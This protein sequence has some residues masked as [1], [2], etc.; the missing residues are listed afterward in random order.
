MGAISGGVGGHGR[1]KMAPVLSRHLD[2]SDGTQ[3]DASVLEGVVILALK[4]R[5]KGVLDA[6][7]YLLGHLHPKVVLVFSLIENKL[8]KKG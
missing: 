5:E 8:S 6:T 7:P 2:R 3:A 1:H 4:H